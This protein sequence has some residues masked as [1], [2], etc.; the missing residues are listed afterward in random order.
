MG[1][2]IPAQLLL[3]AGLMASQAVGAALQITPPHL[4]PDDNG[5][6]ATE[7]RS[8]LSRPSRWSVR[9]VPWEPELPERTA[10]SAIPI[11]AM[12]DSVA[13]HPVGV[14]ISPRFFTLVASGRQVVR[15]RV[16]DRSRRY[17]LL[18]EQIPSDDPQE[19]G[20]NFRFRFS[21]PV[22]YSGKDPLIPI[23]DTRH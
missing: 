22:Y 10:P 13:P 5:I 20:I 4:A 9:V 2:T 21:L 16:R 14:E 3:L 18:I 17:R 19:Q 11:S 8:S 12:A 15:A 1:I 23:S 7:V 6:V